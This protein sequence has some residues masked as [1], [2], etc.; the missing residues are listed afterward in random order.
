MSTAYTTSTASVK[1]PVS[2]SFTCPKC[3]KR[4]FVSKSTML[5]AQSTVQGNNPGGASASARQ[6]LANT[7]DSQVK[8]IVDYLERGD[9]RILMD[10][11]GRN[12]SSKVHCPFCDT[13]QIVDAG[14]NRKTLYPKRFIWIVIGLIVATIALLIIGGSVSAAAKGQNQALPTVVWLLD[15][16]CVIALIA[17]LALNSAQ[18]KNAYA[19]PALMEKRYNAVLNPHMD[20]T[21]KLGIG[22]AIHV[23]IPRQS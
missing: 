17:V 2:L 10:E 14:A 16:G 3:N 12:V 5:T 23:D 18:S 15:L 4:G 20:A 8:R 9:L 1:I 22:N 21:L 7:A 19:D 11:S 13:R 6:S